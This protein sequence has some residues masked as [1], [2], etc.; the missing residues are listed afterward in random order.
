MP[1]ISPSQL[2]LT[3]ADS[4]KPVATVYYDDRPEAPY[5]TRSQAQ[6][7]LR[8]HTHGL[9]LLAR[10]CL[11]YG[12]PAPAGVTAAGLLKQAQEIVAG[13]AL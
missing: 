4:D 8:W 11:M 3:Y 1:H 7:I 5:M 10:W 9:D 12:A 6:A 13:D 2:P